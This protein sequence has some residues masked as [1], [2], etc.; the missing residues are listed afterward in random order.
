MCRLDTFRSPGRTGRIAQVGRFGLFPSL[1]MPRCER[2]LRLR[3]R[4]A[5]RPV[6]RVGGFVLVAAKEDDAI[7]IEGVFGA[8]RLGFLERGVE[9]G[10]QRWLDEDEGGGRVGELVQQLVGRTSGLCSAPSPLRW[11]HQRRDV[12]SRIGGGD[13][14]AQSLHAHDGI[15]VLER[16][17]PKRH[18]HIAPFDSQLLQTP[19]EP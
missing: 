5:D 18:A 15:D 6:W 1:Q 14:T 16:V 3:P 4:F 13:Y 12:L 2:I 7:A 10:E 17:E 8:G 19:S 9:C 11:F